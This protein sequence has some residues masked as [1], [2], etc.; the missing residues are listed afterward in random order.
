MSSAL[1]SGT[2][3]ILGL[4]TFKDVNAAEKYLYVGE[5]KQN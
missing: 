3:Q 2:E 5:R 1:V 4:Q